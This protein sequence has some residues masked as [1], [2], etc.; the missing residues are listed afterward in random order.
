MQITYV[1]ELNDNLI[2]TALNLS[3]ASYCVDNK[4]IWDCTTCT[5][6]NILYNVI[7]NHSERVLVGYNNK[8]NSIFIS[9]RG[10]SNILNWIDNIQISKIYPYPEFQNIGVEKGFYKAYKYLDN[11]I[12][13]NI[14]NLSAK[15]NTIN[16]IITGHSLGAAIATLLSFDIINSKLYDKYN[17]VSLITFGS[18]RVGNQEFVN[19]FN[20]YDIN[21]K[22]IT[23]YY[24]V[25]P[26]VP[27]EFLKYVH[28]S[29]EIWYNEDNTYYT[30]CNDRD[31]KE[32]I[33][34][35]DSC[36]PIHCTSTN[37]HLHY[38]NVSMGSSGD[39]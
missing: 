15:Y 20:Q 7:E 24:D 28:I 34:C 21:S 3:Q 9:F 8:Y 10:S 39:C 22:R 12:Y 13:N 17:I 36:A 38:L 5:D 26:H 35:S 14:I 31:N 27:E 33:T 16:L 11:D 30:I 23:H 1:N 32:D 18:P 25:V 4:N 29:Q 6:D 37:D 19:L 2:K